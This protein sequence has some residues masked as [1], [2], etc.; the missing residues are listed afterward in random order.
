MTE[1]TC[2]ID[3]CDKPHAGRGWCTQHYG[4]WRKT[5]DPNYTAPS[6]DERFH[7]KIN[8]DGPIPALDPTLGPC[9]VWKAF[10]D[11][12][13]Y[14]KFWDGSR[15]TYAHRVSYRMAVGSIPDG[16]EVDHLCRNRACVNPAHLEAVTPRVNN[17]R[18]DSIAS[19]NAR[20]QQCS[21][22][23]PFDADNTYQRPDGL[24]RDCR[25][26]RALAD[27]RRHRKKI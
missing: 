27:R 17:L 9:W 13:G 23:H 8:Q 25:K 12:D 19:Q 20:K 5:G 15:V 11:R 10:I 18:S 6:L 1:R 16:F 26:C 7:A 2:S 24:G 21:L 22:G 4:K 3:G 14:G